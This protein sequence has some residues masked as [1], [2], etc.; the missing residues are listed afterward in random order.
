MKS[1]SIWLHLVAQL[2]A[3]LIAFNLPEP[4]SKYIALFSGLLGAT[5]AWYDTYYAKTQ[6]AAG[7]VLK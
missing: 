1:F 2:L 4:A 5:V 6:I 3:Q 7:A